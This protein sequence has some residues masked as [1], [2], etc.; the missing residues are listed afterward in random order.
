[1]KLEANLN[2]EELSLVFTIFK[3]NYGSKS[4]S[5]FSDFFTKSTPI[6]LIQIN[7]FIERSCLYFFVFKQNFYTLC[8]VFLLKHLVNES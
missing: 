6:P 2:A 3:L 8:L 5:E 1:M 7:L 4:C